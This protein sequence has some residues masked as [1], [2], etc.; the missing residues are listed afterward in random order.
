MQRDNF[1]SSLLIW[2]SFISFSCL[3]ALTSTSTNMLNG[4]GRSGVSTLH[5]FMAM[6]TLLFLSQFL[7]YIFVVLYLLLLMISY[8]LYLTSGAIIMYT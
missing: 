1:T 7:C 2:A 6:E 8:L 3:I 5:L 4:S